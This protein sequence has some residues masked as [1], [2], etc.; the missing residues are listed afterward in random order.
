[1]MKGEA[2]QIKQN[3]AAAATNSNTA[4]VKRMVKAKSRNKT[5]ELKS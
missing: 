1:M 4:K 5:Q 2:T 3:V